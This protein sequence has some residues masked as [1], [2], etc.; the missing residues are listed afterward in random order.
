MN[1]LLFYGFALDAK[2]DSNHAKLMEFKRLDDEINEKLERQSFKDS[3]HDF[4]LVM[5]KVRAKQLLKD[6]NII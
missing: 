5:M 6:L 3:F 4:S 2:A 1:K